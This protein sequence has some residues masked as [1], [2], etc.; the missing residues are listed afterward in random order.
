VKNSSNNGQGQVFNECEGECVSGLFA[1]FCDDI[2]TNAFC[3]NEGS[4]CMPAGS[5]SE[6]EVQT[7]TPKITTPVSYFEHFLVENFKNSL[8]FQKLATTTKMSRILFIEYYG[9]IL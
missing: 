3:P 7:T 8:L 5:A 1:L 9:C 4:C 2:D 6:K